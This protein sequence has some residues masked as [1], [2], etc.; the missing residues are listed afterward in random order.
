MNVIS[1]THASL[2][3]MHAICSARAAYC[4]WEGRTLRV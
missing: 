4:R 3:D 1:Q 2:L